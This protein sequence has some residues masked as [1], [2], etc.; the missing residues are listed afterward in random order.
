MMELKHFV[1]C[2]LAMPDIGS[3]LTVGNPMAEG[4]PFGDLMGNVSQ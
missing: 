1:G 4:K 3:Y 2:E